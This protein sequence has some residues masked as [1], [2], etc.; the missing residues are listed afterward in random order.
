MGV[1]G[2]YLWAFLPGVS[3]WASDAWITLFEQEKSH[4]PHYSQ[5]D[6]VR[7][8]AAFPV[9]F[10]RQCPPLLP[11][12]V[13]PSRPSVQEARGLW[14]GRRCRRSVGKERDRR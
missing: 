3:H 7:R 1:G 8:C 2:V 4:N 13:T 11:R 12:L 9:P 6:D 14:P 5:A 10:L